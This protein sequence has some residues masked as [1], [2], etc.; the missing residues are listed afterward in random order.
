VPTLLA[1]KKEELLLAKPFQEQVPSELDL[2]LFKPISLAQFTF[3]ILVG[4]GILCLTQR[5][6]PLNHQIGKL[7][8]D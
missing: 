8:I 1:L 5:K 7:A 3:P 6:P 2:N 4:V